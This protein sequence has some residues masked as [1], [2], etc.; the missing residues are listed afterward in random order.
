[1]SKTQTRFRS[2]T[3]AMPEIRA[4]QIALAATA[5]GTSGEQIIQRAI[6]EYLLSLAKTDRKFARESGLIGLD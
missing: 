3:V 1:M 4:R 5:L 2:R 6:S